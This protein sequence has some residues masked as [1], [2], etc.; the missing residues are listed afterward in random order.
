MP[1]PNHTPRHRSPGREPARPP[2]DSWGAPKVNSPGSPVS[3]T[4][5]SPGVSNPYYDAKSVK[6][7]RVR[8]ILGI[9]LAVVVVAG[10]ITGL[11]VMAW[12]RANVPQAQTTP[13]AVLTPQG[14][15]DSASNTRTPGTIEGKKE[16]NGED[17]D[18]ADREG[19]NN[20][21]SAAVRTGC[22]GAPLAAPASGN[23][24]T[25]E[26]RAAFEQV[27]R[28]TGATIS[29]AWFDPETGSV[30][31]AGSTEAWVAWSTSK[32]PVAVA[33]SQVG[34][35]QSLAGSMSAALRYSDNGAAET[36]WSSLG[37]T[38]EARA[39]AVTQVL[40]QAGDMTTTVPTVRMR[41]GF[42]V[43]GQTPWTTASQVSF[44]MQLP[45]LNGSDPVVANMSKIGSDQRWGMGQLSG[46]TFKGGWG[47]EASRGY[48][49]RQ[50]GWYTNAAGER[51]FLAI[52]AQ[53]RS[54]DGGVSVLNSL[55]RSLG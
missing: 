25:E 24:T 29:A 3:R 28:D 36:L 35:A 33:V 7:H 34:K 46:A 13:S 23:M 30:Q 45:C 32:V 54:F 37:N 18:D 40:R 55:I 15:G 22:D 42:T 51:V 31:T 44:M 50:M 4:P 27:G 47:P 17:G 38:N 14:E 8:L 10:L 20:P 12:Q 21:T 43:F 1:E 53:A 52:A 49:V 6:R 11:S 19:T 48:L 26:I 39:A 5:V 16:T 9:V 2:L 41:S